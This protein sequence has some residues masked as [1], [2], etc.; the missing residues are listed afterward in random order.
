LQLGIRARDIAIVKPGQGDAVARIDMFEPL[1]HE[2]IVRAPIETGGPDV[3]IVVNA[4]E[5]PAPGETVGLKFRRDRLH[6]F[7]TEDGRRVN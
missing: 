2:T 1:G 4:D 6:L 7:R 3:T 5:V